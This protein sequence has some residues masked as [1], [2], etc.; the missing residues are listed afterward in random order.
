MN[1]LIANYENKGEV[2]GGEIKKIELKLRWGNF[3]LV[4]SVFFS[5]DLEDRKKFCSQ[6]EE[7]ISEIL[8]QKTEILE[9][10]VEMERQGETTLETSGE[11]VK[12]HS[13]RVDKMLD[14]TRF[15]CS[16]RYALG[17]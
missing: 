17:S 1:G 9:E 3:P 15:E 16:F 11:D 2:L 6:Q 13:K 14:Y 4:S 10:M 7:A 12:L 8:K 5:V